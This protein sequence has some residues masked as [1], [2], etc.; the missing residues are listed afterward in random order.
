MLV[1]LFLLDLSFL[2][3]CGRVPPIFWSPFSENLFS[4]FVSSLHTF[5]LHFLNKRVLE[6]LRKGEE[7]KITL[8]NVKGNF[9]YLFQF[10]KA[11]TNVAMFGKRRPTVLQKSPKQTDFDQENIFFRHS[12]LFPLSHFTHLPCL[13][14]QYIL[15]KFLVWPNCKRY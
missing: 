3:S 1:H 10:E 14:A 4:Q 9:F 13:L 8:F 2:M 5:V 7:K 11:L 12:C 6:K 15:Y